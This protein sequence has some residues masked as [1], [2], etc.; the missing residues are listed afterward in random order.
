MYRKGSVQMDMEFSIR[1]AVCSR[2]YVLNSDF[3]K[4]KKFSLLF[5][6]RG[7]TGQ[8]E[9]Y[10]LTQDRLSAKDRYQTVSVNRQKRR[11]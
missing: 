11:S 3:K 7:V 6:T 5:E 2:L 8:H 1:A 9:D 4:K 10:H